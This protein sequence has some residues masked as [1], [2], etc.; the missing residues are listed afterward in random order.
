MESAPNELFRQIRETSSPDKT[1]FARV[2]HLA[3]AISAEISE[4]NQASELNRRFRA[5]YL[6]LQ[7]VI[8]RSNDTGLIDLYRQQC[9]KTAEQ[10]CSAAV[11]VEQP[12]GE[13]L[14]ATPARNGLH[15]RR[16][17]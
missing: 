15:I 7:L 9:T 4:P 16:P 14:G 6:D 10:M 8:L 17:D 5:A 13:V 3:R 12:D 1:R 2:N 11:L